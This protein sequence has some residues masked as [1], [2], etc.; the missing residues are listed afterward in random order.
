M[1]YSIDV[2]DNTACVKIICHISVVFTTL[3]I[4]KIKFMYL[5]GNYILHMYLFFVLSFFDKNDKILFKLLV[6]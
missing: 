2:T 6:K 1:M 4:F 3:K 5:N